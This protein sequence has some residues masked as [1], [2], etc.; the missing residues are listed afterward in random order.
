M[1]FIYNQVC[2]SE[3]TGFLAPTLLFK[4]GGEKVDSTEKMSKL[5]LPPLKNVHNIQGLLQLTGQILGH[6]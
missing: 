4:K 3:G 2:S 1:S 5:L 6:P